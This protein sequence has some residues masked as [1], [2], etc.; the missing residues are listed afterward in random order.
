MGFFRNMF[1]NKQGGTDP[2]IYGGELVELRHSLETQRGTL[3]CIQCGKNITVNLADIEW[4]IR[5]NRRLEKGFGGGTNVAFAFDS[6]Q[7]TISALLAVIITSAAMEKKPVEVDR[8]TAGL[9]MA[10]PTAQ[11]RLQQSH[12]SRRRQA[13]RRAFGRSRSRVRKPCA[14]LTRAVWLRQPSQERPS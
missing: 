12:C 3:S 1:G 9:A 5:R 2:S 4:Q 8:L 13:G 10:G 11:Q 7:G 6:S 14:A